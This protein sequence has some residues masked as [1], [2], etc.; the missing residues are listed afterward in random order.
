[1]IQEDVSS[2]RVIQR[3]NLY[4]LKIF[5]ENIFAI[6]VSKPVLSR[7]IWRINLLSFHELKPNHATYT[8]C[9]AYLRT[10]S[11]HIFFDVPRGR[12]Q[13]IIVSII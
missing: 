6:G 4:E 12:F 5:V 2:L 11:N 9:T 8:R 1:M 13:K 3:M 10:V 7:R